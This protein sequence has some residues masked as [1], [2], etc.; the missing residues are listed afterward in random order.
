VKKRLSFRRPSASLIVASAA[1]FLSLG[2]VG[3]AAISLPR[4]SVGTNQIRNNAVHGSKINVLAVGYRKIQF[5]AVGI[6]RIN[7]N[8]VQARVNGTCAANSAMTAIDN[9]G[10]ATCS[11]T[12]PKEF[13]TTSSS[14]TAVGT[15]GTV[16]T[17][18][19]LP[20]GTSY[21]VFAN[22]QVDVSGAATGSQTQVDCTLSMSPG[23]PSTT[24]TRSVTIP[25]GAGH[26]FASMS[27][28][29]PAPSVANGS[30]AGVSCVRS[31]TGTTPTTL[32]VNV[33]TAINA[34]QTAS[35]G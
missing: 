12:A 23:D 9:Q 16:V 5:G 34:L 18:K 27:L 19:A 4:N 17:T 32:A 6:R 1:L 11:A 28:E 25:A 29:V 3:Y 15:T 20:G 24:Q 26:Q 35:N 31:T 13:G 14:P 22:P 8:Q 2:G 7:T 30:T 33:S 21:L 10:N